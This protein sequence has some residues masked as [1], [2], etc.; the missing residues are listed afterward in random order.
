MKDIIE[1][2]TYK[3][4][5]K[6]SLFPLKLNIFHIVEYINWK[7]NRRFRVINFIVS[8]FKRRIF[9]CWR[10]KDNKVLQILF[11]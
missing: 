1:T 3:E 9:K 8:M 4:T 11:R 5:S 10:V 7:E 2:Y 6:Y